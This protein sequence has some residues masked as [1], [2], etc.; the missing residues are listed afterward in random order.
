MFLHRPTSR[1]PLLPSPPLS[2]SPEDQFRNDEWI[3]GFFLFLYLLHIFFS[4]SQ[5][6]KIVFM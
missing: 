6:S 1:L 5:E 3:V 2:T 4:S